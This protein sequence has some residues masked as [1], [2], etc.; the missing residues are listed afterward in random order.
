MIIVHDLKQ[1]L[2]TD[3]TT[4]ASC[5]YLVSEQLNESLRSNVTILTSA[6]ALYG[7][8]LR[9]ELSRCLSGSLLLCATS[10]LCKNCRKF[11]VVNASITTSIVILED[12]IQIHAICENNANF[13]DRPTELVQGYT[14]LILNIKKFESL[15]QEL[16]LF[17][18]CGTFLS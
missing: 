16:C 5:L 9:S 2:D 11:F 18:S 15:G 1:T 10:L 3:D 17:H 8:L 4:C 6:I 13:L 7:R 14:S 12:H